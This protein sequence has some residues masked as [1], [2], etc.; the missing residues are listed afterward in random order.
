MINSLE[1]Y[2]IGLVAAN[3][4]VCL[5][6]IREC[7]EMA[8]AKCMYDEETDEHFVAF[9]VKLYKTKTKIS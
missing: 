9:I 4:S 8:K 7:I 3:G 2:I 6:T 1:R 5:R